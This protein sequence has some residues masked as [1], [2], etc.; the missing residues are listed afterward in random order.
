MNCKVKLIFPL[1]EVAYYVGCD[2]NDTPILSPDI[3]AAGTFMEDEANKLH[4]L[5]RN[6]YLGAVITFVEV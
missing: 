2:Y 6:I 4:E 3:N 1:G 5:L